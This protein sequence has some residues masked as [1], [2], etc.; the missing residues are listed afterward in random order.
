MKLI[1][2]NLSNFFTQFLFM[3]VNEILRHM[4]GELRMLINLQALSR[5]DWIA[6]AWFISV[7]FLCWLVNQ[8]I[9][10]RRKKCKSLYYVPPRWFWFLF[11][12]AVN[13]C[14]FCIGR[15][16]GATPLN[17]PFAIAIWASC[18]FLWPRRQWLKPKKYIKEV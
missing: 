17:V 7:C 12:F 9:I 5:R 8:F 16:Y 13:V 3:I 2:S 18:V 10:M 4:F 11:L 6:Y 15:I 1:T 14:M